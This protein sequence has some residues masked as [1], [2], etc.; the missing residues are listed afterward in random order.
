M[1]DDPALG[2]FRDQFAGEIGTISEYPL[3]AGDGNPGFLGAADIISTH[4]LWERWLAGPENHIDSRA[5]L[6]ARVLDLW[7]DNYDRHA[8]QW[9]W[10]RIPGEAR[11]Q[12]LP[13]DP[14]MVLV[15]HD[16]RVMASLRSYV[17]KL[18]R[19]KETYSRRLEGPL[20]NCFEVDRWLL[21]DLERA[22]WKKIARDAQGR[23]TDE[24]IETALRQMPP[25]WYAIG[26]N[27]TAGALKARRA[28]LVEYVLRVY[29]YYAKKVD[30]HA[31]DQA[32]RVAVSRGEDDAIEISIAV[33]GTE[34]EPYYR[35]RFLPDET[36]EV[37][38]YLH[39]GDDRVERTGRPKGPITVRVIAGG[40]TDVVDDSRSGGTQV[41]RD[42]GEVEV[43]RGRGTRVR[44]GVW[45][46]P[47]PERDMPWKKANPWVEPRSYGHWTTTQTIVDWSPDIELLIGGGLTRRSWGF[48][49]YPEASVQTLRAA[50]ASGDMNGKAEY[51]GTFRK[52]ASGL[53]L[54]L[55][56]YASGIEHINF[57]G[58][59]NDTAEET[60][61]ER[62][63]SRQ[64]VV[65]ASP[66]LRWERG[67]RFE[68]HGG[69]EVRLS[70]SPTEGPAIVGEERL[71]G[72]G[73]FGSL[74]LKAGFHLDTRGRS[75][76]H[77]TGLGEGFMKE[78]APAITGLQI[79]A[80]G[81]YVPELWDAEADYG[82]VDGFVATYLGNRRIH[83]ALRGGGR[84][85]WGDSPWF[86]AAFVG[87]RNNRGFRRNRFAG[88]ASLYGTAE[89]RLWVG[90][91]PTPVLPVRFGVFGFGDVGRVWL[92]GEDSD[93]WHTSWGGGVLAQPMDAPLTA[94]ASVG[95]STEDT[96][97]YFG[98]GYAF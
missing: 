54:S 44:R 28:E 68:I 43:Q 74:T 76:A 6:R 52:A 16:G 9:R 88:D 82:W 41:W 61:R 46:N 92:T 12:P 94:R 18:L 22:D 72:T 96:H 97:F 51:L 23:F 64:N 63:Q 81:A 70:N 71:Y 60:D 48:R 42:A 80:S 93:T 24:V 29:D 27:D 38:I 5:L 20:S 49:N 31:T 98:M 36:D 73:D 58:F 69:P 15:R 26:G 67:P 40:G 13:E 1:P 33:D 78:G 84:K 11:W 53:S 35:R 8:G 50:F 55:N 59:G 57:F 19:F 91:L 10:L 87:G 75:D 79:F 4:E 86:D 14:D 89:L 3:P 62:Y 25:E 85:V 7:V 47:D 37:R 45:T 39:G 17:P 83:L 65:I 56:A 66:T 34:T 90:H 77:A 30:V 21:S 2:E 32:E 95:V